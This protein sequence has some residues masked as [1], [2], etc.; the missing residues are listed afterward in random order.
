M[1]LGSVDS[2]SLE[3]ARI[4][5]NALTN[6][7]RQ[8]RDL[9]AEET[10]T[11]DEAERGHT[12]EGLVEEYLKRRVRSRLKTVRQIENRLKRTLDPIFKRKAAEIRRRDLRELFDS[13]AD[14]GHAREA[15]MRR[16]TVATLFKWAV[17]Q[18]ILETSPAQGLTAYGPKKARDRVL[19]DD[20]VSSPMAMARPASGDA[21]RPQ[22]AIAARS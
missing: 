3:A 14:A 9:L 17:A 2:L 13:A 5:A 7:A 16:M 4:R 22:T 15:E 11:R 21:G 18:D 8:G 10:Q 12:V 1:S 20:E 6:A 19:S